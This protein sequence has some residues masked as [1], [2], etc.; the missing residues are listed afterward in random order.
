MRAPHRQALRCIGCAETFSPYIENCHHLVTQAP[1]AET[2]MAVCDIC[3]ACSVACF[4]W[5]AQTQAALGQRTDLQAY[6]CALVEAWAGTLTC[7]AC[8]AVVLLDAS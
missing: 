1:S 8:C 2:L 3:T 7:I 5:P 6:P 4:N